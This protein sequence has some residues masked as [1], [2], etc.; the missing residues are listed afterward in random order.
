MT[1][2][3]PFLHRH[4]FPLLS[5]T[6]YSSKRAVPKLII[7][8]NFL[9]QTNWFRSVG[10][11]GR[12][13]RLAD[14]SLKGIVGRPLKGGGGLSV[15]GRE[16]KQSLPAVWMFNGS[17]SSDRMRSGGRASL[18]SVH[19]ACGLRSWGR[20]ELHQPP[21]TGPSAPFCPSAQP[22]AHPDRSAHFKEQDLITIIL[23]LFTIINA[24]RGT[25]YNKCN[26]N[27]NRNRK[28]CLGNI[29]LLMLNHKLLK[30]FSEENLIFSRFCLAENS[31]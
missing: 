14:G 30:L 29:F 26:I 25:N 2:W 24:R 12:S 18:R 27:L 9:V 16:S 11:G 6:N 15:G 20:T 8:T 10:S 22:A 5:G 17:E 31:R 23:K 7:T 13:A 3:R 1:W 19:S 21:P 4:R 28:T